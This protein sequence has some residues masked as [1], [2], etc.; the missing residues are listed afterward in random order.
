MILAIV[1]SERDRLGIERYFAEWLRHLLGCHRSEVEPIAVNLPQLAQT[2]VPTVTPSPAPGN[3]WRNLKV[4]PLRGD[5]EHEDGDGKF[6]VRIIPMAE[7]I[8]KFRLRVAVLLPLVAWMV[9]S[10]LGY[11]F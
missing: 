5:V 1:G 7:D 8:A 4:V 6:P 10:G 2:G 9:S 3:F 11:R